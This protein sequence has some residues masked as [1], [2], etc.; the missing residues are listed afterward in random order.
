[1]TTSSLTPDDP[2]FTLGFLHDVTKVL[3]THGYRPPE[4][5]S[6]RHVALGRSM[7]A[8]LAL[9]RAYEGTDVH[10][11]AGPNALTREAAPNAETADGR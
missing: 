9:T 1:M 5:D 4:D 3:E 7:T 10:R 8:L 11:E 2:R 6:G